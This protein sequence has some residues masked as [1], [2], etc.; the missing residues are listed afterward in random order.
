MPSKNERSLHEPPGETTPGKMIKTTRFRPIAPRPQEGAPPPSK[1]SSAPS[2]AAAPSTTAPNAQKAD[3][4]TTTTTTAAATTANAAAMARTN[5]LAAAAAAEK[6]PGA[7]FALKM[8]KSGAQHRHLAPAKPSAAGDDISL[9]PKNFCYADLR[10]TMSEYDTSSMS[11]GF[12][13]GYYGG[14]GGYGGNV[15]GQY[16]QQGR[17]SP[18]ANSWGSNI[19]Y[20]GQGM[21]PTSAGYPA[22]AGQGGQ[23]PSA[24]QFPQ[25]Q[26]QQPQDKEGVKLDLDQDSVAKAFGDDGNAANN[27]GGKGKRK[28]HSE[29]DG[30]ADT[31]EKRS[32]SG[33]E[34]D[35]ANAAAVNRPASRNMMLCRNPSVKGSS[36]FLNCIATGST[37]PLFHIERRLA[38]S[39]ISEYLKKDPE[40]A[41]L[42]EDF[43]LVRTQKKQKV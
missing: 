19:C 4:A 10:S 2:S 33:S 14:Y 7:A 25:Q 9:D 37:N 17:A 8:D 18:S 42:V 24:I 1:P 16:A 20:A 30:S 11:T 6:K 39:F 3:P 28:V 41:H 21:Y 22:S 35:E 34:N 12:Y 27:N 13:G 5:K 15:Y 26:Q 29:S 40:A 23:P 31:A 38:C 43:E 36:S 32:D